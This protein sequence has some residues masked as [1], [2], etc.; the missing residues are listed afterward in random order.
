MH[1]LS[2]RE[3]DLPKVTE[4]ACD[5]AGLESKSGQHLADSFRRA[6]DHVERLP[7]VGEGAV[8]GKGQ[9][10]SRNLGRVERGAHPGGEVF[11]SPLAPL[12]FLQALCEQGQ[13]QTPR[14]GGGEGA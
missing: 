14:W 12:L 9:T 6:Q 10:G 4:W 11:I 8:D 3:L 7:S 5:R 2:L 1:K 13:G